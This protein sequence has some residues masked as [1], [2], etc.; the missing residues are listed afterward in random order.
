VLNDAVVEP[1]WISQRK[2]ATEDRG[3]SFD[4]RSTFSRGR[5]GASISKFR[6]KRSA[7][8]SSTVLVEYSRSLQP[9][10]FGYDV[11]TREFRDSAAC[12]VFVVKTDNL[13]LE[14]VFA[15]ST[16]CSAYSAESSSW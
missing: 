7:S 13:F 10:D 15:G 8:E 5:F 11:L 6:S 2:S 12:A 16:S 14:Q 9:D 4:P 1:T 3:D